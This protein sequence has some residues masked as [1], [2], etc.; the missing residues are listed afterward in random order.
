MVAARSKLVGFDTA[1]VQFSNRPGGSVLHWEYIL[2][3]E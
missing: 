1:V 2:G 3:T